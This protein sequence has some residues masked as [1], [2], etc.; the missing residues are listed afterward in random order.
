MD[1]FSATS[2]PF[3][4]SGNAFISADSF[5]YRQLQQQSVRNVASAVRCRQVSSILERPATCSPALTEVFVSCVPAVRPADMARLSWD[6]RTFLRPAQEVRSIAGARVIYPPT[7]L[8]LTANIPFPFQQVN[9][10]W[11]QCFLSGTGSSGNW[12]NFN[13]IMLLVRLPSQCC[14]L[15]NAAVPQIT[16]LLRWMLDHRQMNRK[17]CFGQLWTYIWS[18]NPKAVETK[19]NHETFQQW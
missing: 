6:L 4:A 15:Y 16:L 2:V 5:C 1:R 19:E 9:A 12:C 8:I 7:E 18:S 10:A 14:F 13:I 17:L 3:S 11:L